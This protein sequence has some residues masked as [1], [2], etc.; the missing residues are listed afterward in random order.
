MTSG[1]G[2]GAAFRGNSI[3]SPGTAAVSD[4]LRQPE[5]PLT[6]RDGHHPDRGPLLLISCKKDHMV[7][8]TA[9]RANYELYCEST[10]VM[11]A[12]ARLPSLCWGD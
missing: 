6:H 9:T 7:P 4:R 1:W 2:V 5:S 11:V 3:P 8:D 10:S 12:G